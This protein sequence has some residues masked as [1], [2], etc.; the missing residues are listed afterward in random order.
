M[1]SSAAY[2]WNAQTNGLYLCCRCEY[3]AK[4]NV[5]FAIE[6]PTSSLVWRYKPLKVVRVRVCAFETRPCTMMHII[7]VDKLKR[8]GLSSLQELLARHH[9]MEISVPLGAYGAQTESGPKSIV[10]IK[11]GK[12]LF[13]CKRLLEKL[14]LNPGKLICFPGCSLFLVRKRVTVFTNAPYLEKIGTKLDPE[15]RL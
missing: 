5:Y 10:Y 12:H 11:N 1:K 8:A 4:K 7:C 3:L 9:A 6:N 2:D 14:Q 13:F 15:R